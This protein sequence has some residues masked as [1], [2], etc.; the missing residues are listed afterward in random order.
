MVCVL[1]VGGAIVLWQM[2]VISTQKM[3]LTSAARENE[4]LRRRID[5]AMRS[6][7]GP[8]LSPSAVPAPRTRQPSAAAV[9]PSSSAAE[10]QALHLRESLIQSTAETA[11][12]EA[13]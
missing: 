9:E 12:L 5:Q 2:R 1:L 10:E 13:R 4:D 7:P 11:R 8:P 6:H 3:L